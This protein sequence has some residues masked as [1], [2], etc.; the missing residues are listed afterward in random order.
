MKITK[1]QLR[2]IIKEEK[3]RLMNEAIPRA[4]SSESLA[5]GAA[6]EAIAFI[7]SKINQEYGDVASHWD[8]YDKLVDLLM[9]YMEFEEYHAQLSAEGI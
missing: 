7:Q 3:A 2:R 9:N 6:D 5:M 8:G 1:R 4:V